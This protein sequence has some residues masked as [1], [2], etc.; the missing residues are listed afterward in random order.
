MGGVWELWQKLV[1]GPAVIQ[2][3][4]RGTPNKFLT[5]FYKCSVVVVSVVTAATGGVVAAIVVLDVV[6]VFVGVI[7]DCGT[8]HVRF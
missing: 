2:D 6:V 7:Y 1:H 8:L 5:H 3:L 4:V